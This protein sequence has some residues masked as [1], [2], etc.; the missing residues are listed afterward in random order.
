[1][2]EVQPP[3]RLPSRLQCAGL[4]VYL[5]TVLPGFL[6]A[7]TSSRSSRNIDA[8]QPFVGVSNEIL[9]FGKEI[10]ENFQ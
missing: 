7:E 5:N 8:A 2:V 6:D 3:C 4:T 9:K 1:M 10:Y